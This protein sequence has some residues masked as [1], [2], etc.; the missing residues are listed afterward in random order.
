MEFA[1]LFGFGRTGRGLPRGSIFAQE[2]PRS[3]FDISNQTIQLL[4]QKSHL[5]YGK[6]NRITMPIRSFD[7]N[8]LLLNPGSKVAVAHRY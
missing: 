6:L 3:S 8:C 1:R 5:R 2:Y 4:D 7:V